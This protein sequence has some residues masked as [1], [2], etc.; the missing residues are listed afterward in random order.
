ME[1]DHCLFN[2]CWYLQLGSMLSWTDSIYMIG[3][4]RF[5]LHVVEF[6]SRFYPG[7]GCGFLE[8]DNLL[9]ECDRLLEMG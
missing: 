4:G 5:S 1:S 8:N 9:S 6:G 3:F 2:Y 7:L